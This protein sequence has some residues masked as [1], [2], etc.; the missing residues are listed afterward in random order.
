MAEYLPNNDAILDGYTLSYKGEILSSTF[1]YGYRQ[2]AAN[3]IDNI[4][5]TTAFTMKGL[6]TFKRSQIIDFFRT[7]GSALPFLIP[8]QGE[9]DLVVLLVPNSYK[10]EVTKLGYYKITFDAIEHKFPG[11]TP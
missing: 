8:R 6:S 9:S 4:S 1:G 10:E 2:V 11:V 3:G 7:V 5:Y